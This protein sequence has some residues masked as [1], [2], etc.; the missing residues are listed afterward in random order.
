MAFRTNIIKNEEF[1]DFFL[2]EKFFGMQLQ[3]GDDKALTRTSLERLQAV[4][5]AEQRLQIDD[6]V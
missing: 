1:Y 6:D 3:S 5:S 2:N 4:P